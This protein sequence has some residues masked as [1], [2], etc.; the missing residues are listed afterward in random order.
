MN[1]LLLSTGQDFAGIN[2]RIKQAFDR[3]TSWNVRS[4]H[5]AQTYLDYPY[6]ELWSRRVKYL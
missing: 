4:L 1:V 5:G 3:F 6:D 2:F